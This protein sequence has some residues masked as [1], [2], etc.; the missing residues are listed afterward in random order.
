MELT[1]GNGRWH[2]AILKRRY[3]EL[4]LSDQKRIECRLTRIPCA[5]FGRIGPGE[6]IQ[7]SDYSWG[8]T[9]Y[10]NLMMKA[11]SIPVHLVLTAHAN[12]VFKDARLTPTGIYNPRWQK[13]TA[14]YVDAVVYLQPPPTSDSADLVNIGVVTKCRFKHMHEKRYRNFTFDA[15]YEDVKELL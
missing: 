12:E 4:I 8:N 1:T 7:P 3:L 10:K 14:Q 5:P 6:R 15:M 9:Y 11:R 2:I 13:W